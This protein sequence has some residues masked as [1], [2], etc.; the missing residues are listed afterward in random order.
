MLRSG[1]G[2]YFCS[3]LMSLVGQSKRESLR[4]AL[5]SCVSFLCTSLDDRSKVGG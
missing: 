5:D 1:V 4:G 2:I 3:F